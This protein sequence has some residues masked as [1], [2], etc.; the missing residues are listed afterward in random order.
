MLH[1][2]NFDA[3]I[4]CK[5][6]LLN[7]YLDWKSPDTETD[8]CLYQM[9]PGTKWYQ[10]F[11]SFMSVWMCQGCLMGKGSEGI[12]KLAYKP[13]CNIKWLTCYLSIIKIFICLIDYK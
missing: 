8:I 11:I 7:L 3:Y 2:C 12:M 4:W 6:G 13:K 1:K 9:I 5:L 10:G